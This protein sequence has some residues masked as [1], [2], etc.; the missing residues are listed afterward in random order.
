MTPELKAAQRAFYE[1]HIAP[2]AQDRLA[3]EFKRNRE[4]KAKIAATR[5]RNAERNA[6]VIANR[7]EYA[8]LVAKWNATKAKIKTVA[9]DPR[10]EPNV[11]AVAVAALAKFRPVPPRPRL[12]HE[13]PPL[14]RTLPEWKRGGARRQASQRAHGGRNLILLSRMVAPP[15]VHIKET[16]P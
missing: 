13:P 15:S 9:N 4:I 8:A 14:P 12:A 11:R 16:T 7:R 1:R 3:A 2:G 6:A 10:I 5:Q